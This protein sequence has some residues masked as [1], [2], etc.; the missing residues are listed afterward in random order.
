M[1]E[2]ADASFV[3]GDL[4]RQR[5]LGGK[6]ETVREIID[7]GDNHRLGVWLICE[8]FASRSELVERA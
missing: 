7:D 5:R 4:V 2:T 6:T 3:P 1:T 8:T